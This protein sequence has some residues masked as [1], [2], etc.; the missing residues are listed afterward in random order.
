[1]AG[2]VLPEVKKMAAGAS[3][4]VS[5]TARPALALVASLSK[6]KLPASFGL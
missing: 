1:L 5:G 6:L 4:A 2:P 3:G